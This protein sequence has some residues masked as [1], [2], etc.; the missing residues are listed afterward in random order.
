MKNKANWSLSL[1]LLLLITVNSCNKGDTLKPLDAKNLPQSVEELWQ[2]FDPRKEPLDVEVLHEWE[3]DSVKLQVVRF[4]VGVFKGKKAMVAGVYG[5]PIGAKNVPGLVNLHGGGQYAD[6]RSV[7]TNAKRGYA[8]ITVAWAGRI[9]TPDYMVTPKDVKLFFNN[10]T[11]NENY[12]ITTDWGALDGYHAP[13][14]YN[15][16]SS[17][18]IEPCEWNLDSIVSPR[19]TQWF[20]W[21]MAARRAL[22]FLE[23][24][25]VVDK[26]K[27]GIYGHSMGGKI[28]VLTATDP[29]VKVAIPSCGGISGI[30]NENPNYQA[31]IS[32]TSSLKEISCPVMFLSPSNDFNGHL[33]DIPVAM[34]L[35]KSDQSRVVSS[36]HQSHQDHPEFEVSGL[37]WI[38]QHLKG[39]FQVP[40]TPETKLVLDH[41]TGR[42][43]VLV[44]PD[45]AMKIQEVEIYF[46]QQAEFPINSKPS[47]DRNHRKKRFWIYASPQ[48]TMNG[49]EA[50]LP[51]QYTDKL[52][53][54]YAN[55][56]YKL[57]K[58]Y[59][60]AGYYYRVYTTDEFNLSSPI[61]IATAEQL[62]QAD[63]KSSV[64]HSNLIE[65]FEKNWK[66]SWFHYK[67][68]VLEWRTHKIYNDRWKAPKNASLVVQVRSVQDNTLVVTADAYGTEISLKGG[69]RWQKAVI[70]AENMKNALDKPMLSWSD[71]TELSLLESTSLQKKLDGEKIIVKL[72][73]SWKGEYPEFRNMHWE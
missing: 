9:N 42:V 28:T 41:Q 50:E 51:L 73:S 69:T 34:K 60:G 57:D 17:S 21:S 7:L 38:D 46:T 68:D 62:K 14:R 53:W 63:I 24:Q 27:L 47:G 40:N 31:T 44:K 4:R 6:Y 1:L 64:A 30:Y 43:K 48:K 11:A 67:P 52:L 16:I 37:L 29:R 19:N 49:W 72:G 36:A 2:D 71:V 55:V 33:R 25:D 23:Q 59:T 26:D 10:D 20:L 13:S 15:G 54:A 65:S 58:P 32:D 61:Q 5:W 35:L 66:K 22:T 56:R 18:K 45:E 70:P 39:N 8:T 12:K 3:E